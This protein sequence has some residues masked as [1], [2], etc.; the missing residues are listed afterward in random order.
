M[1]DAG[2]Q[3]VFSIRVDSDDHAFLA[4]GFVN[5]NTESK[6]APLAMQL[7]GEI[8]EDT[9]DFDDTYDGSNQRADR[10]PG[11][12]PEPAGQRRRRHRGR[13]GHQHPA[14]QPRRGHRRD[15]APASTTPTRRVDDLMQ[16]VQGPDFPTGAL[17]LGRGRH[18]ATRYR[19]GRG[20]IKMRAVA[21]IEEDRK[22]GQRIV[23]TEVP[24]QTSVEVIG[25]EDRRAGQRPQASR[26]SATC[27]T[28]RPAT[29]TRLVVELKRDANA[30][31][32]L[33]QLY[34]HTPMQTNF[35]VNMLALVDG[36]PRLLDLRD[37][38]AGATSTHQVEV[39][40]PAHASTGCA[41]RRTARTSSR[42]W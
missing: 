31:V 27:A 22:G 5:H 29:P 14:A 12:V 13:D 33:N 8:D 6:L 3:P 40:T 17:I 35:A 19:T 1:T 7:L 25:A 32:V 34:K 10:A 38:A 30:Q 16:F 39:I 23:V 2:V 36:V 37:G 21:E 28:S 4:A 42:A 18:R 24:Y 9:V 26:A 41:R 20:S 15:A 11:A